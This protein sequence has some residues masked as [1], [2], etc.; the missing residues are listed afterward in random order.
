MSRPLMSLLAA[1]ARV[2]VLVTG[3]AIATAAVVGG[4]TVVVHTVA[5]QSPAP[6]PAAEN[7][8]GAEKR[9]L[10]KLAKLQRESQ[11]GAQAP[12]APFVCDP[13]KTHG[14][15]ISAYVHSLPKGPGRGALVSQAA[16]SDCGKDVED[17]DKTGKPDEAAKPDKAADPGSTAPEGTGKP[18]V[19]GK[20]DGAGKPEGTGKPDV[21]GKSDGAGKPEGTG[22]P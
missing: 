11:R 10:A 17:T 12:A 8:Q 20:S 5:A 9:G 4:G 3:T 16:K 14:Q 19:T 7:S 13:T 6:A 15:N 1:K 21:T 22:K 18:D 2:G